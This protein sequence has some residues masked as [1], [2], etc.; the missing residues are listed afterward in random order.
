M[1][2]KIILFVAFLSILACFFAIGIS[3]EAP[4]SYI[5]FKVKLSGANEYVTAYV[6]DIFPT[7]PMLDL[8]EP[9]Y[10]DADFTQE[11]SQ[12]QI[13][14]LDFSNATPINSG[15]NVVVNFRM[16]SS[17]YPNCKEIKWFNVSGSTTVIGATTFQNWTS[18]ESF[19]LGCA[20]QIVDRAFSG[21]GLKALVIP[22]AVTAIKG[23]AFSNNTSLTSVK[24]EG[25]PTV[26]SSAFQGCTS[27]TSID[28]GKLTTV[29]NSMFMD[30]TSLTSVVLPSTVEKI[31]KQAFR[32]CTNLTSVTFSDSIKTIGEAAFYGTGITSATIPAGVTSIGKNSF[33]NC[34]NLASVTLNDSLETIGE[35]AFYKSGLTSVTIP[36]SVTSIGNSAFCNCK[37]LATVEF[38]AGCAATFGSSAFMGTSALTSLTLSEGITAIPYQCF[39]QSGAIDKVVLPDSVK[40]LAGRAFS[41]TGIKEFVISETSQLEAITGDAFSGA[42]YIK[43][44]YLPTGVV[45]SSDNVFQY[46]H[47]LEE[48]INLENAV[49]NVASYG[50][51]VFPGKLFYECV[52]LKE[53]KISN[54]VTAIGGTA[55]RYYGLERLYIPASVTSINSEWINSTTHIPTTTTIFYCGGDAQK[56]LSLTDDEA[57]NVS[58]RLASS[59]E[60]GNVAEYAGMSA[61]YESG[62]IVINT[63]TCD[64][65][66]G[67]VHLEG[68]EI[69]SAFV[70]ENGNPNGKMYMSTF[71]ISC[72]CARGCGEETVLKEIDPLFTILGDSVPESGN[73]GLVIGFLVNKTAV[74]EYTEATGT[75]LNYGLFVGTQAKLGNNDVMDASGNA[76]EGAIVAEMSNR[77]FN[78]F[79]LKIIGFNDDAQR[80][81]KLAMGAYVVEKGTETKI[82]YLQTETPNDGEK[83]LYQSYN[84]II[85]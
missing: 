43:S 22:E 6:E 11:I 69:T 34:T 81:A 13:V 68:D 80:T 76:P 42:K 59:I 37:S 54:S 72:P 2:K 9:F 47:A 64:V 15:K 36:A 75:T 61:T 65:Y 17:P 82:S 23:G 71:K 28:F 58:T 31:D 33:Y 38:K 20:T 66:F 3:A 32:G 30:C 46:C 84:D 63:N 45:I 41:S 19:D 8:K 24:I 53:I 1:K 18:L 57:G 78:V 29:G 77:T 70:D 56:L 60:S 12:D 40:T 62:V 27:L 49:F 7:D 10:S 83:Y 44:I 48:V 74:K 51:N 73:G 50:E 52:N 67:G 16:A 21:C 14:G 5:E 85:G 26:S 79:E 55:F 35:A 39:W 25:N 4:S